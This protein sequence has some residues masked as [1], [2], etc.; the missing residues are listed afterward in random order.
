VGVYEVD[1]AWLD[2]RLI[3]ELDSLAFHRTRAAFEDDRERD[4]VLQLAGYRV[5][6]ITHRRM[7][8]KPAE[9]VDL[10]RALLSR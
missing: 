4:S 6:R 10:L 5:I 2:Q 9:V 7:E 3:V 8:A 1:V